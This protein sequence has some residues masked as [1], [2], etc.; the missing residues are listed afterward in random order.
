VI[1][2]IRCSLFIDNNHKPA[3]YF[4]GGISTSDVKIHLILI[5]L[6]WHLHLVGGSY[7]KYDRGTWLNKE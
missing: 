5:A 2:S 6:P 1:I 3:K 4:V 7:G